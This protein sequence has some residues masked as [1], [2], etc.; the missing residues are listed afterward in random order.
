MMISCI[1]YPSRMHEDKN[2]PGL[3]NQRI[4]VESLGNLFD[5]HLYNLMRAIQPEGKVRVMFVVGYCYDRRTSSGVRS[6]I[7]GEAVDKADRR[8]K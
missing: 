3:C 8:F 4:T 5:T 1:S 7:R 2:H 6:S